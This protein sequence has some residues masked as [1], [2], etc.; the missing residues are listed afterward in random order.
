MHP[1]PLPTLTKEKKE[2][3]TKKKNEVEKCQTAFFGGWGN[4][5]LTFQVD[6]Q[7]RVAFPKKKRKGST[8]VGWC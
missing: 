3:R 5:N 1:F 7:R 6:Q 4:K 8:L 2:K